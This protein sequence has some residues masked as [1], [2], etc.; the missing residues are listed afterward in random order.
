MLAPVGSLTLA[1]Q[2]PNISLTW[3]PPFT[4][5]IT[6]TDSSIAGYCVEVL[7]NVVEFTSPLRK[8]THTVC[9]VAETRFTYPLSMLSESVCYYYEFVVFAVNEVGNG[10]QD[11][12]VY[13]LNH[14][15]CKAGINIQ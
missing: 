3:T 2:D 6:G 7:G 12:R 11:D 15:T 13:S 8:S 4:L 1:V 10:M 14:T 5:D 9:D